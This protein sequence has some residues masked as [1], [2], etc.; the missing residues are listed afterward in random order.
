MA[1]ALIIAGAY[2]WGAVPS[3]YLAGRFLKGIDIR[4]YG[5][6]NVGAANV[7]EH[8][9]RWTG[10]GLGAFDMLGKGTL[11]IVVARLLDQSLAAQ[12]AVG[13]AAIAGHNWSP[14]I[15]FT[16]GRGLATAGGV[17]LGLLMWKEILVAIVLIV[18]LGRLV[19]RDVAFWT[20]VALLTVPPLAYLFGQSSELVYMLFGIALL[21]VLKRLTANWETPV[22][23][24]HSVPGVLLR[25]LVWDRDV[26]R[27]LEWMVRRPA[28]GE[29][30]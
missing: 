22:R 3:A 20:L 7:G 23:D 17:L 13:A 25:R 16:G 4:D 28:S 1:T 12:G 11:P 29:R 8:V 27:R 5:S 6:G 26:A 30:N 9:G 15:G 18:V 14:Y 21:L 10:I 24:G 19:T 2:L